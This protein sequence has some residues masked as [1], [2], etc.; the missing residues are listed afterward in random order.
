VFVKLPVVYHL[1]KD[2]VRKVLRPKW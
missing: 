2:D 1:R